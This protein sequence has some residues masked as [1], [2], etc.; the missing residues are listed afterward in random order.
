M[1]IF[2]N[3]TSNRQKKQQFQMLEKTSDCYWKLVALT[4]GSA[5]QASL[6]LHQAAYDQKISLLG[7]SMCV[8]ACTF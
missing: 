2:F 1:N 7:L 3:I 8:G 5:S 4:F 6:V